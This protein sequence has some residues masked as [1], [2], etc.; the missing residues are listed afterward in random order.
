MRFNKCIESFTLFKCVNVI[1]TV[2]YDSIHTNKNQTANKC[3]AIHPGIPIS[4]DIAT[5]SAL[6]AA[7]NI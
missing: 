5:A 4:I 6:A 7:N 3:N 1:A 2:M